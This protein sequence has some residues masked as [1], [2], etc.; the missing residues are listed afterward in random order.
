[1]EKWFNGLAVL[2]VTLWVGGMWATG[3][4]AVP[5]LFHALPENRML[6]GKLAGEMFGAMAYA[7]TVCGLYL[8]GYAARRSG[9]KLLQSGI[10]WTVAAM[11]LLTLLGHFGFQP[12]MAQLKAGALPLDVMRSEYAAHFSML[13]GAASLAYLLQSL[14]GIMLLLKI[15]ALHPVT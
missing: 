10:F 11:L 5:V 4:L 14:L 12:L 15:H 8:L 9:R 2:A 3:Y 6:A 7:G 13:H 1:V